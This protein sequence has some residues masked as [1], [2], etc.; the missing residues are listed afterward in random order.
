VSP[1][2][3]TLVVLDDEERILSALRRTLRR[4][5][6]RLLT[7]TDP[8]EALH[9]LATESVDAVLSDAR[10]PGIAGLDFLELAA[11][12][13]PGAARLLI[14]GWPEE[15]PRE[16]RE[17]LGVRAVIPKPWDDAELKSRLREVL[18]RAPAG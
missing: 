18:G 3:A 15:V 16:R 7:T 8:A 5:G 10:M 2:P 6:W 4:E 1:T 12:R 11:Q 14:T 9:W 17:A 13:C